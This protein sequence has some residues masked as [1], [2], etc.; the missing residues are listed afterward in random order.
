MSMCKTRNGIFLP[1]RQSIKEALTT[2]DGK[3][4]FDGLRA[5]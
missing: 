3:G 5:A 4:F 1:L 2:L